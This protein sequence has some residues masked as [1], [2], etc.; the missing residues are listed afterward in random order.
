MKKKLDCVMLID[1][2]EDDNFYH[3]V[4]LERAGVAKNVQ[5]ASTAFEA[6]DFLTKGT[7]IP[8]IIFLDINM[9]A[10]DG[11]EFMEEYMRSTANKKVLIIV[12]TTSL[13]PADR[14][15]SKNK[16]G[17][18]EFR[19]KPLTYEMVTEIFDRYFPDK[20]PGEKKI[21]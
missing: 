7:V 2:N 14:E 13:N 9:P 8:D 1:D 6:L 10:M 18:T 16:S 3:Q 20:M 17:I 21:T 5:I 11:W 4:V 19:T 15:Y 12:L